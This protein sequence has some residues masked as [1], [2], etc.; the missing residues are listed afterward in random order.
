MFLRYFFYYYSTNWF[1]TK[2]RPHDN[3]HV[4]QPQSFRSETQH[5]R[6]WQM[7]NKATKLGFIIFDAR[8]TVE[9]SSPSVGGHKK[10]RSSSR[11]RVEFENKSSCF[12]LFF[13]DCGVPNQEIR[14]V[15]GRPTGVNRYP[16]VARLVYDGHFHCGGSLINGDYVLTAAHCVR[17][18]VRAA[19]PPSPRT[20]ESLLRDR[21]TTVTTKRNSSCF[22]VCRMLKNADDNEKKTSD[23]PQ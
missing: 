12:L 6:M 22:T 16:W 19:C 5:G 10:R 18:W 13:T 17:K 23:R 20:N 15:G 11:G 9:F 3:T 2:S 14:I 21:V 7:C 4:V 8:R 1:S